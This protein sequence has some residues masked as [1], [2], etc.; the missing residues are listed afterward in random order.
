MKYSNQTV[1]FRQIVFIS[2]FTFYCVTKKGFI[3][4]EVQ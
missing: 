4:K 3:K 1:H 2:W